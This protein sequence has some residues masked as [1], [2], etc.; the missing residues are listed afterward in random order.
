MHDPRIYSIKVSTALV[1]K[2]PKLGDLHSKSYWYRWSEFIPL[3]KN[4]LT[5][6]ALNEMWSSPLNYIS[7]Y[8]SLWSHLLKAS[9]NV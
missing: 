6:L 8:S 5:N 9:Y 7:R 3:F 2:T 4:A 1:L